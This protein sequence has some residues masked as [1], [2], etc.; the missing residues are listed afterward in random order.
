MTNPRPMVTELPMQLPLC[1]ID[2]EKSTLEESLIRWSNFCVE[3][4]EKMI[5]EA[6]IKLFAVNLNF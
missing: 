3:N 1:E 4:S 5:K 2:S 6:A